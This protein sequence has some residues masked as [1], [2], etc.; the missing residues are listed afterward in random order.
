MV[1]RYNSDGTL[2]DYATFGGS[3]QA[4]GASILALDDGIFVGGT[5]ENGSSLY[6]MALWRF[7]SDLELNTDFNAPKGYALFSGPGHDVGYGLTTDTRG[8]ILITGSSHNGTDKD[9]IACRFK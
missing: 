1:R 3:G 8:R 7:T 4:M 9:I 2:D 6:D 5:M